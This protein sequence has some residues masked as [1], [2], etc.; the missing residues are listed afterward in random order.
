M[1]MCKNHG[2]D[3]AYGLAFRHIKVRG[4]IIVSAYINA[5]IDQYSGF[6]C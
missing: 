5:A 2:I 6:R 4:A 3:L 1:C